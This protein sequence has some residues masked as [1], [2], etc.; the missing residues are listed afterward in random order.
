LISLRQP[1]NSNQNAFLARKEKEVEMAKAKSAVPAGFHTITPHLTLNNAAKTIDW[2]KKALGAE[3]VS[4]AV[5]PDGKIMHAVLRIGDSVIMVNDVM[6]NGKG[7]KE[8]GGSPASLWLYVENCDTLFNRA[9]AAGAQVYGGAM[10]ALTD[11]FWGDRSGTL[12][13][14]EGYQWTIATHKEDLTPQELQQRQAE[15][16]KQF[17]GQAHS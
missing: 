17:A 2:Y 3:E 14:P 8:I 11:Q 16:M 9:V 10:G 7:P 12:I 13:D 5:G 6:M 1:S 15:F 4:R